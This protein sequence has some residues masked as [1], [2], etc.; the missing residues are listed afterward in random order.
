MPSKTLLTKI[1]HVTDRAALADALSPFHLRDLLTFNQL[2]TIT[3]AAAHSLPGAVEI[4]QR[5]PKGTTYGQ[6]NDDKFIVNNR[7]K[8]TRENP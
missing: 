2:K 3:A 5:S 4:H 8:L 7:A 6:V 1:I